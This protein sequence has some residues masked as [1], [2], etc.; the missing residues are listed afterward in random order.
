MENNETQEISLLEIWNRLWKNKYLII[1]LTLAITIIGVGTLYFLNKDTGV[2]TSSL[3]FKF[4]NI[5][6]AQYPDKTPFNFRDIISKESLEKAKY[7]DDEFKDLDVDALSKDERTSIARNEVLNKQNEVIQ[8]LYEIKLPVKYFKN[9]KELVKDYIIALSNQVIKRASDA[10]NSLKV[11]NNLDSQIIE[12][13]DYLDMIDLIKSQYSVLTNNYASFEAKFGDVV[14]NGSNIAELQAELINWYTIT[15]KIDDLKTR[16]IDGRYSKDPE[17]KKTELK[18]VN[19]EIAQLQAERK[20]LSEMVKE[21]GLTESEAIGREIVELKNAIVYLEMLKEYYNDE[22]KPAVAGQTDFD[23][24]ITS[25]IEQ[26]EKY[27]LEYDQFNKSVLDINTSV[28]YTMGTKILTVK[29]QYNMVLMSIVVL[30]LGGA[31]S[32]GAALVKEAVLN[33]KE[34]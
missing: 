4:L 34:N 33:K 28:Y 7:S 8:V 22:D 31:V 26:L 10:N 5:E 20:L 23:R 27:T 29:K 14:M 24:E 15:V 3:E 2:A 30:F 11:V 21:S 32:V 17:Y 9:N 12:N 1:I 6:Q 25:Y 16:L 13:A 19:F 18:R